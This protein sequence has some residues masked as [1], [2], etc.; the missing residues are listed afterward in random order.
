[1]TNLPTG[2][3]G[4][5]PLQVAEVAVRAAGRLIMER[6][7]AT[8]GAD[9]LSSIQVTFK[10]RN[11][12]VTDVDRAAEQTAVAILN[13]EFPQFDMLAEESGHQARGGEF[14]W[15]LDPL[16]GTRNFAAGIPQFA[17]NLALAKGDDVL[18]GLTYDPTRDE[19]FHAEA[20][21]GSHLNGKRIAV[22]SAET[23]EQSILG[24][25][26]GY[27]DEKA[28]QLL[29]VLRFLWPG[30]QAFRIFGS[31]ALGYAYAAAGR[32]DLYAHH[33]LER[34]DVAPGLLLVREAGGMVTDL[35]GAGA[36]MGSKA[37]VAAGPAVHTRFMT[38]TQDSAW[39][40]I[41]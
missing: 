37:A 9:A 32:L 12:L 28:A 41:R 24:F 1:L 27:V 30:M 39:R 26:L 35:S 3:N 21:R 25:D 7:V 29:E 33:H 10:G 40:S 36:T 31:A 14:T 4:R 6:F 38:A 17:V 5:T 18:L 8:T 19:L 2:I 11:D 15:V 16:D 20:G 13:Q 34:W 23:L 22:S